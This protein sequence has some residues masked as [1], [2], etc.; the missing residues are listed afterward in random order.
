MMFP[1]FSKIVLKNSFQKY[2]TNKRIV[3]SKKNKIK[4]GHVSHD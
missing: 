1:V 3:C 4:L 2:E